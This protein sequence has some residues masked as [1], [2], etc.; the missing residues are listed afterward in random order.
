MTVHMVLHQGL[1]PCMHSLYSTSALPIFPT[2]RVTVL[3]TYRITPASKE[4][5]AQLVSAA[6]CFQAAEM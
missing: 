5:Q 4:V 1:G 2:C 6:H 3:W